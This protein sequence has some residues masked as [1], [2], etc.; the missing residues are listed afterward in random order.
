MLKYNFLVLTLMCAVP[1]FLFPFIRKDLIK[2]A[3]ICAL[4]ALP[5]GTTE[6]MFYPEY[7][8]P[9]F[10]FDLADKVGFGIEDFIFVAA[11]AV[12]AFTAYPF[13]FN[14]RLKHKN[15]SG[16]LKQRIFKAVLIIGTSLA[17]A[18]AFHKAAFPLI[19][20]SM[21]IMICVST[22]PMLIWRRDLLLPAIFGALLTSGIYFL[23]CVLYS[24]VYSGVFENV[25]RS[26]SISGFRLIRGIP[27]E[28]PAYAFACGFAAAFF[29]PFI[30]SAKYV[31]RSA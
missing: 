22:L 7:W 12:I 5:F 9:K 25:W 24:F 21:I 20:A 26:A 11:L 4:C 30:A 2:P 17:C 14:K 19:Y 6:F 1:A 31:R 28:E 10:L 23:I 13:L 16:G 29:Y 8:Q 3:I 15:G 18:F 27:I